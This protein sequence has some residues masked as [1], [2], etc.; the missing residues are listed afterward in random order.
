MSFSL[1]CLIAEGSAG[2]QNLMHEKYLLELISRMDRN[3]NERD[4]SPKRQMF[5]C[6]PSSLHANIL[7]TPDVDPS[8]ILDAAYLLCLAYLYRTLLN[9]YSECL[10]T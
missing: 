9:N 3:R 1:F 4:C 6:A 8:L 10:Y 2:K 5:F 7:S